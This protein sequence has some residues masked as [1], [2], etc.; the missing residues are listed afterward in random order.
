MRIFS[1]PTCSHHFEA[2]RVEPFKQA[3]QH[4]I[5]HPTMF[6]R[7]AGSRALTNFGT[8]ARPIF[9]GLSGNEASGYTGIPCYAH[10]GKL[11]RA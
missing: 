10:K 4:L 11:G 7:Y 8:V 1:Q 9:E 2:N 6:V 5:E 3:L